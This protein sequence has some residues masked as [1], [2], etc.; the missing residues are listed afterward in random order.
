VNLQS[1]LLFA[2]YDIVQRN[3]LARSARKPRKQRHAAQQDAC[4]A[5]SA[6]KIQYYPGVYNTLLKNSQCQTVEPQGPLEPFRQGRTDRSMAKTSRALSNV[7]KEHAAQSR[8][9]RKCLELPKTR[10]S[11]KGKM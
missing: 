6:C 9:K 2:S 4:C 11:Q 7:P 8:Q 3:A 5:A 10:Q 1:T